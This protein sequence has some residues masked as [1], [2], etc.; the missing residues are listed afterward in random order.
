MANRWVPILIAAILLAGGMAGGAPLDGPRPN[1]VLIY[2]DDHDLNEVACYG[3][4]VLSPHMDGLARDGMKFTRFYVASAV[5][6]PSRFNVLTGRYASRSLRFQRNCPPGSPV[7]IGWEP[8]VYG[9]QNT[10]AHILQ[11]NG[12]RTGMVGKWHQGAAGPPPKFGPEDDPNDSAV[13]KRLQ[14]SYELLLRS[15]R[16]TGF[17]YAASAYHGNVDDGAKGPGKPGN[18][19]VPL[20][21]HNMEWVT[22][23]ALEF[24]E[25]NANRPFFLYLAP[26]LVHGPSPLASLTKADPR[27]TSLGF[28]DKAP[29]VQPSRQSVLERV[30]AAGVAPAQ[31]G[32]TWLDDG[33]G[34]VLDKL[35]K[36]GLAER[37]LVLLAGDNGNVAKFTCYDGGALMPFLA[38][39]PGKIRPGS[40]CDKLTANIDLAPTILEVCGIKPPAEAAFDGQNI[41]PALQGNAA[42]QRASLMLEITTERAIVSEDGFKYLAVRYK[43][44]VLEQMAK[45]VKFNHWC[46]PMDQSTHSYNAEKNYP[47]YWDADQL[48]DLRQDPQ[49][50]KNLAAQP[51]QK[52]RLE[53]MKALLRQY[54]AGLPHSF[55]EFKP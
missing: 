36:L 53:K 2:T 32:V 20:R 29:Q 30:K 12:Y 27:A 28:L 18:L 49:E 19:P 7:N 13:K 55:G 10:L 9:E 40:V 33:V 6:S 17:D 24:I 1:V 31:A 15:I 43:P 51:S 41:W 35:A 23:G 45:G 54:S 46:Q 47:A 14:Q 37:T 5:C 42:Y 21:V 16:E 39:W 34:A 50:Q 26:T 25:Q 8:G 38:R 3:G 11:K 52:E 48:Y 22:A 4:K 44:A